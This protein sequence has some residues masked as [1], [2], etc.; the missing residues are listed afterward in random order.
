MYRVFCLL[1]LLLPFLFVNGQKKVAI[2][3]DDVPNSGMYATEGYQC[4]LLQK[5]DSMDLPVAI[6]INEQRVL[7]GDSI[8]RNIRLFDNWIKSSNVLLGN[9]SFNHA[10]YSVAGLDLFK[11]EIIKGETLTKELGKKYGKEEKYFRFPY[12]DLG[13]NE[14]EHKAV[15]DFLKNRKYILTPFTVHSDDWLVTELYEYYKNK[16]MSADA[17][18]IGDAFVK[19][20]LDFFDYIETLTDKKQNR[21]VKQIYLMH[22]NVLNAD[23]LDKLIAA[24]KNKGY[25]FITLDE[26]MNDPVYSQTDYYT[27][28]YGISWV[29]RWI[30]DEKLRLELMKKSPDTTQFEKE[31]EQVKKKN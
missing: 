6:F 9:H 23:Y 12:N 10:M 7:Q 16:G 14:Q 8:E 5:I 15:T 30:K 25:S 17:A 26:A 24:L 31:L 13:N 21:N 1:I 28:K 20:T 19:K 3:I 2:T 11:T 29:Y 22:D 18:R 4:R 27:Q